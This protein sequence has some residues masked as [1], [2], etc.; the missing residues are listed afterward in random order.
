MNPSPAIQ[1]VFQGVAS[2]PQMFRMFDRHLQRPNR[3][4]DHAMPLYAGE[5]FEIDEDGHDYMFE[6]LPPLWIRGSMF[7]MREFL[8]GSVTSV[9]FALRIDEAIRYFHGYCD[10]SDPSSV[11][12]MRLAIIERESRPV[13]AMTREERLEHIW[14]S[15]ADDYRGYAGERWPEASRGK[16]TVMLYGGKD[17]T[18]LK[19]LEDLSDDEIAA[20][21]PVQ[22]RHLRSP[23]AA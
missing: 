8:T 21:L 3:W 5:W 19:L 18:V 1:K 23:I 16:R 7:A 4:E 2:R 9:F 10:L 22:L 15:T 6:I 20:K 11:E 17:G 13:R 12:T 14:S